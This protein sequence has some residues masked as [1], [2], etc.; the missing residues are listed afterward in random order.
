MTAIIGYRSIITAANLGGTAGTLNHPLRALL[1]GATWETYQ[2]GSLPATVTV[3]GTGALTAD[4]IGVAGYGLLTAGVTI[5]LE[6][7][8]NNSTWTTLATLTAA[9]DAS[10]LLGTF[11]SVSAQYWRITIAGTSLPHICAI[12]LGQRLTMQRG[13]Y[14]GH[15]PLLLSATSSMRANVSERGYWL[16]RTVERYGTR[17]GYTFNNLSPDWYRSNFAPFA[18]SATTK[19]FFIQWRPQLSAETAYCWMTDDARVVNTGTR[20]LMSVSFEVESFNGYAGLTPSQEIEPFEL[21]DNF[22]LTLENG[23]NLLLEY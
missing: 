3:T 14:G 4:Y 6:S 23:D 18:K 22:A 2:P 9:S 12:Y 8:P 5:V 15:S 16:G 11:T 7:S 21:E 13:I 20:G 1:S 10:A 17:T 19:P